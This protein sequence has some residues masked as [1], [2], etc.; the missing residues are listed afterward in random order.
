MIQIKSKTVVHSTPDFSSNAATLSS[1]LP[2]ITSTRKSRFSSD[3]SCMST[4]KVPN[5]VQSS[6]S[7]Y[8]GHS[9]VDWNIVNG[10]LLWKDCTV[11]NL[12]VI[13]DP[14]STTD[15]VFM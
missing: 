4:V 11:L 1:V 9:I 12:L 13:L 8:Y 6:T 14:S 10:T 3:G 2:K 7:V 5:F 15:P